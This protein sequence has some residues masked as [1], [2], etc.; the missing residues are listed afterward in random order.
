MIGQT[1]CVPRLMLR[2]EAMTELATKRE[3]LLARM[4]ELSSCLVAYSGGV[5]S[6]VVAKAAVLALGDQVVAATAIS[7]SMATGER[8]EARRLASRIGVRHMEVA[9]RELQNP[10]YVVNHFDR[11]FHCKTELYSRLE[12]LLAELQLA[13]IAN[14]ANLDDLDDYRPGLQAA[15]D[16]QVVSPLADCGFSKQDVRAVA[17]DWELPVAE[18]PATPCLSSRI[19]YG[20]PVTPDRLRMIDAAEQW[21]RQHGLGDVRVRFHP[22]DLARLEIP[23]EHLDLV[24]RD[25]L[26]S[27]LADYV[28][29]LGFK[30]I[31]VDLQ[32]RRSGSLNLLVNS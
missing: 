26:R 3:R 12:P 13:C 23:L 20:E 28:L 29:S 2:K 10:L 32:G 11:C 19:A 16:F 1:G 22:G 21:L 6:A 7:P 15:R 25:P 24:S 14:G 5:D 8:E 17:R 18:K 30:F 4:R 9:T 31:T 27:Q